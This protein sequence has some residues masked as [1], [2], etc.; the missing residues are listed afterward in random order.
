MLFGIIWLG[1]MFGS[2]VL[3]RD[4]QDIGFEIVIML[5]VSVWACDSFAFVA[6][7]Y[8]GEKKILP[9]V[10][11]KNLVRYFFWNIWQHFIFLFILLLF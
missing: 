1:L 11:P 3:L 8:F 4:L 9:S 5:F 2:L 6:G 10:S 7:K